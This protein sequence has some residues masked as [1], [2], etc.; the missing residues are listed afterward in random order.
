M[1]DQDGV[2]AWDDCGAKAHEATPSQPIWQNRKVQA[3][4]EIPT[5]PRGGDGPRASDSGHDQKP[6]F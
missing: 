1:Q 2:S 6:I 4:T 3:R 5:G